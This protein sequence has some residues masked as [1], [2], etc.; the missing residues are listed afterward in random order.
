MRFIVIYACFIGLLGCGQE[1]KSTLESTIPIADNQKPA[2]IDQGHVL[3]DSMNRVA[4]YT[5]EMIKRGPLDTTFTL[6]SGGKIPIPSTVIC[7]FMEPDPSSPMNGKTPKFNCKDDR[8]RVYKV[9]YG[10][11]NPEVYSE[12]FVS[13]LLWIL[14]YY[15]DRNYPVSVTCKNCPEDP[16]HYIN[17]ANQLF[18]K[19][20]S[21]ETI[22]AKLS[23]EPHFVS[24]YFAQATIE[25]KTGDKLEVKD[26]GDSGWGLDELRPR[27]LPDDA[28]CVSGHCERVFREG[29]LILSSLIVH[30]DNKPENQKIFCIEDGVKAKKACPANHVGLMIQD[31]GASFFGYQ[32]PKGDV[33]DALSLR[34]ELEVWHDHAVWSLHRPC[35]IA[36]PHAVFHQGPAQSLTKAVVSEPAR[37]FIANR[38]KSLSDEQIDALIQVS[39]M[40]HR[41]HPDAATTDGDN[42]EYAR[43]FRKILMDRIE[44]IETTQCSDPIHMDI[45]NYSKW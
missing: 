28:Q 1:A 38:L 37:H 36:L 3:A 14:G 17:K 41:A 32:A 2:L 7:S 6:E 35:H 39:R 44:T 27:H 40:D 11:Y 13:R 10:A 9:K 20:T 30:A 25:V 43:H 33:F 26:T 34:T 16:W 5:P 42:A 29:M 15:A 4:T 19:G 21:V 31:V 22:K 18:A 12:V 24:K 45:S 23:L 8:G